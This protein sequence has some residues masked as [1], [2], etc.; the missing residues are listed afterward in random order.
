[1]A[2]AGP[3]AHDFAVP[4]WYEFRPDHRHLA[5]RLDP[6]PDLSTLQ[7]D[8]GHTDVVTDEEFFHQLPSQHQH[9]ILPSNTDVIGPG[10]WR[11]GIRGVL[12]LPEFDPLFAV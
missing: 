6:E 7:A 9:D 3:S 11:A 8:D 5:R 2:V 12:E 10:P 4:F 1:M